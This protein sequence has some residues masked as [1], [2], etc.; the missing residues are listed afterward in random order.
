ME[1]ERGEEYGL[2]FASDPDS[3]VAHGLERDGE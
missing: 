2:K 3:G 1:R